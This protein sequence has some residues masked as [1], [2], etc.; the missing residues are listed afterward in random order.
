MKDKNYISLN[1][2]D[3]K[4]PFKTPDNYFENFALQIDAKTATAH[5]HISFKQRKI[6]MYVAAVFTGI[7]IFGGVYYSH[8][9]KETNTYADNYESYVLSQ[10]DESSLMDYY[11]DKK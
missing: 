5:K 4:M 9:Q 11:V 6:W 10:V 2:I 1:E 8:Q 3:R 7:I